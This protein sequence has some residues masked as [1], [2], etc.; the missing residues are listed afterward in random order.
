MINK[1][2][3]LETILNTYG[4]SLSNACHVLSSVLAVK[5]LRENHDIEF[6]LQERAREKLIKNYNGEGYNIHSGIIKFTNEIQC[7]LE[8]YRMFEIDDEMLFN[9]AYSEKMPD[10]SRVVKLELY[11]AR[12]VLQNRKKDEKDI[13]LVKERGLW[14][15]AFQEEVDRYLDI[16]R[17]KGFCVFA[18]DKE[19][20]WK[21]I[22]ENDK[23]F[24]FGTGGIAK[25]FY[26]RVQK[27]FLTDKISG[28]LVSQKG[29]NDFLNEK[30][31]YELNEVDKKDSLILIAVSYPD[32]PQIKKM[33]SREGFL[34][35]EETYLFM[36]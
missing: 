22:F 23:I 34:R 17:K 26:K 36:I 15:K 31:I 2:K 21:E 35:L 14:T 6:V 1:S 5:G 33:L 28:F 11:M 27:E 19:Q 9:D 16:A 24:I 7:V 13:C 3:E 8:P 29:K 18:G 30:K 10:G 32:V 4:I 25:A 20:K 12:K